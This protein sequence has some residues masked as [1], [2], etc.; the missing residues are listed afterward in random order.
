MINPRAHGRF[1]LTPNTFTFTRVAEVL[2]QGP[3]GKQSL[4]VRVRLPSHPLFIWLL[5]LIADIINIERYRLKSSY[6]VV[7]EADGSRVER[8]LG[9]SGW[10][11]DDVT[12]N[13]VG[14]WGAPGWGEPARKGTSASSGHTSG[15]MGSGLLCDPPLPFSR[16]PQKPAPP[17][18]L[19]R[20][21]SHW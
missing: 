9:M 5:W 11:P 7:L 13:E 16:T 15:V 1:L 6:G 3:L 2:R 14:G 17:T 10:I 12:Y 21:L 4:L 20:W 8:E 19:T 18:F